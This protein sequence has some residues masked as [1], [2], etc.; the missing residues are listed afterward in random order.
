MKSFNEFLTEE[1]EQKGVAKKVRGAIGKGKTNLERGS[2][3]LHASPDASRESLTASVDKALG[4]KHT[5]DKHGRAVWNTGSHTI[6]MH[7]HDDG[8]H[9]FQVQKSQE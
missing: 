6:H 2:H 4:T 1:E 7:K 3:W 5:N 9:M 8:H